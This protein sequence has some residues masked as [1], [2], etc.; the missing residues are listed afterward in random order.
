M[1][2]EEELKKNTAAMTALTAAIETQTTLIQSGVA[3]AGGGTSTKTTKSA[4][5][6]PETAAAKKKRPAAKK[7]ANAAPTEEDLRQRFGDYL[8]G[9]KD[10][11]GKRRLTATVKQIL[12]HLGAPRVTEIAEGDRKEAMALVDLLVAG[13]EEDGVDGAEAVVLPFMEDDGEDG[14][15][16][17]VL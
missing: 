11:P 6:K 1:A 8:N 10:T 13:F 4:G 14:D 17:D 16:S 12:E 5:D 7:K 2:L 3:K 9:V 15:D